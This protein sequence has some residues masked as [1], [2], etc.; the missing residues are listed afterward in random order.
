MRAALPTAVARRLAA[1]RLP[2][3]V[4]EAAAL[5]LMHPT[6][7]ASV[8]A[9]PGWLLELKWDGVRV[10][11]LR[12][13]G[14]VRLVA[15]RGGEVTRVYP[16]V[17]AAL[18]ALPGGDLALDGEIVVLD[19]SGRPSFPQLAR[20]IHLAAAPAIAAAAR[21]TPVTAFVFDL[22]V[23]DG[24]DC[25]ALP[26]EVRKALLRALVPS[27]G[28]L[29]YCAHVD[30][31]G[32]A[33]FA[34]VCREGLEGVVAKRADAPYHG[35]RSRAWLKVKCRRVEDFVIGGWTDP[36]GSRPGLGAVHLGRREGRDLV[37]VGRVGAGLSERQLADL[38]A[39][40][41]RLAAARCPFTRGDP[42]RGP[43]HHWVRPT[44]V[45]T[46]RFTEWTADGKVRHPVFVGL[47]SRPR[48][49][50]PRS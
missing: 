34:A 37:Y 36:R 5:P 43:G 50:T 47:R 44:L 10:L 30:D 11:A 8:P 28:A 16:E 27:A 1:L 45:C 48:A 20:R 29:R 6:L 7:V 26:L 15:R 49:A 2:R 19:A 32:P 41:R 35:G 3:L 13:G 25:R 39:R 21:T 18:A 17:A 42:P 12:A 9:G 46:V 14:A 24:R 31:D 4:P 23:L 22:L 38:E 40:L 33:F